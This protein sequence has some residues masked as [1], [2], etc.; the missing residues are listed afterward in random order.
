VKSEFSEKDASYGAA[1]LYDIPVPIQDCELRLVQLGEL[2]TE[3]RKESTMILRS[4]LALV[5]LMCGPSVIAS[6]QTGA[7]QSTM[8]HV[9]RAFLGTLNPAER[10][11]AMFPFNSEERFRWFYTP[12]PRKGISL[13]EMTETQKKAALNLLRAGL[14]EKGYSKVETIRKLEE[15]LRELE[16]ARRAHARSRTVL[17]HL[18]RRAE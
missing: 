17:L 13:R 5:L 14:S 18:L 6:S 8:L 2:C 12:V 9:S 4:Q 7:P 10:S 3:C 11:Q 1:G 16:Q 15:V